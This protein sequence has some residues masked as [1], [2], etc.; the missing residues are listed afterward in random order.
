MHLGI[1]VELLKLRQKQTYL[2]G[3]IDGIVALEEHFGKDF[4][5]EDEKEKLDDKEYSIG[6]R[7]YMAADSISSFYICQL[8]EVEQEIQELLEKDKEYDKDTSNT[9]S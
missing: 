8:E 7:L 2:K 5:D 9:D 1:T 3:M 6:T 4:L